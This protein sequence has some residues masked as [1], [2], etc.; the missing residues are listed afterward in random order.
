MSIWKKT[1]DTGYD[2]LFN[3]LI[4]D[5]T[6]SDPSEAFDTTTIL[7]TECADR[8]TE[9]VFWNTGQ[10]NVSKCICTMHHKLSNGKSEQV[11]N[12]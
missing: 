6:E 9:F 12:F 7:N 8:T 3:Y 4:V 10:K 5:E 1:I 11:S 2:I